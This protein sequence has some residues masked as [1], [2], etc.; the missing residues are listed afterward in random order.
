[1][2]GSTAPSDSDRLQKHS[3]DGD[4]EHFRSSESSVSRRFETSVII[5]FNKKSHIPEDLNPNFSIIPN[6][7]QM[8][9]SHILTFSFNIILPCVCSQ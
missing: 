6:Q 4:A 3:Y 7:S 1:M 5:H 8:N 2:S 9:F